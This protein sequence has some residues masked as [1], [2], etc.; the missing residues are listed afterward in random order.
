MAALWMPS[1]IRAHPTLHVRKN[2][3]SDDV[4]HAEPSHSIPPPSTLGFSSR[5]FHPSTI[6]PPSIYLYHLLN[7]TDDGKLTALLLCSAAHFL[8]PLA[9]HLC[10]VTLY[11]T[12]Q[13]HMRDSIFVLADFNL[14]SFERLT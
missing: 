9:V 8:F 11:L 12:C 10:L 6:H 5:E 1:S 4:L 3:D 7:T 2:R 13:F 14:F